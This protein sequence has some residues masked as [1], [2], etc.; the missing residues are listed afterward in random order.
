MPLPV[1]EHLQHA[2]AAESQ[3]VDHGYTL[4]ALNRQVHYC[5]VSN[6][7]ADELLRVETGHLRFVRGR[8]VVKI[9]EA[10]CS[11]C[12]ISGLDDGRWHDPRMLR[13]A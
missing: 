6:A 1:P 2:L 12:I 9:E 4:G 10:T 11:A 13:A 7:L 3:I 5:V 8:G